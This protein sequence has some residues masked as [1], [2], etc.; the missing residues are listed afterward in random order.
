MVQVPLPTSA[1]V[2]V[3]TMVPA[4]PC[5]WPGVAVTWA[6]AAMPVVVVVPAVVGG[7]L[8]VEV[9]VVPLWGAVVPVAV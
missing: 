1:N 2:T 5:A 8:V 6:Q 4:A 7:T 9:V 3:P